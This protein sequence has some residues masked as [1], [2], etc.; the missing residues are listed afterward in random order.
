MEE[1]EVPMKVK[2]KESRDDS[3]HRPHPSV[4]R[5]FL[6]HPLAFIFLSFY[7]LSGLSSKCHLAFQWL[8]PMLYVLGGK[9]EIRGEHCESTPKFRK[10][11]T[12]E[13]LLFFRDK[14]IGG[15][16]VVAC[17]NSALVNN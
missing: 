15:E 1:Y 14:Y 6:G 5:E 7:G 17:K 4:P 3:A 2:A 9:G 11:F 10:D 8:F 16:Q 13:V 12:N